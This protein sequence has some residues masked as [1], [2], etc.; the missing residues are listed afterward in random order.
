MK[1]DQSA[2]TGAGRSEFT[3]LAYCKSGNFREN[4]ILRI[5]L[6]DIFMML[7]IRDSAMI[8]VY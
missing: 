7:K 8:Y 3:L 5:A 4:F 2:P 1:P 6:K